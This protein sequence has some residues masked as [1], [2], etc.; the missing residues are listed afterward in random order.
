MTRITDHRVATRRARHDL[1][2]P[3][4]LAVTFFV[5]N[6]ELWRYRKAFDHYDIR[7]AGHLDTRPDV[8]V[9]RNV[10]FFEGRLMRV[11]QIIV[12]L[13]TGVWPYDVIHLDGDILNDHPSNLVTD[14][15]ALPPGITAR[16]G[17]FTA[18]AR[19]Y[20]AMRNVGT[21]PNVDE[22]VKAREDYI[23]SWEERDAAFEKKRK[24]GRATSPLDMQGVP[25]FEI[26]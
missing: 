13:E 3:A 12:A 10:T 17:K 20:G 8:K 15:N 18:Y 26:A 19:A 4:K 9:R 22:A 11:D 2:D 14:E 6:G 23:R 5:E 7:P 25:D 21:F 24:A 1:K 16:H